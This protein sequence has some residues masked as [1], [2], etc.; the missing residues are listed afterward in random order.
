MQKVLSI[1]SWL[2]IKYGFDEIHQFE[3]LEK[4]LA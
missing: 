3:S 2:A 4:Q 1:I